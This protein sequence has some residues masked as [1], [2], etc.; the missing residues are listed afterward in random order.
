MNKIAI[1]LLAIIIALLSYSLIGKSI[2]HNKYKEQLS[3]L[4]KTEQSYLEMV[5]E[6]G[7]V[8]VEQEQIMLSQSD[9]I[10]QGLL[11]I[12]RLKK[13]SSEVRVVTEVIIDTL[14]MTHTDTVT[15]TVNDNLYLRIPQSYSFSNEHL[16]I[17]AQVN[18]LGLSLDNVSIFNEN[19]VTIGYK[20]DGFFKP[21]VPVVSIKNTNPYMNTT[22]VSNIIIEPKKNLISDKRVWV[23]GGF[24][25]GIL[26][27]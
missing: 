21:L 5:D 8:I 7:D 12:D 23:I 22:N 25:L 24:I 14:V 11:E 3:K 26:I 9:A 27:K 1:T 20:K 2:E 16:S 15:I 17:A 13:V 6:Q 19:I 4:H 18:K 10:Q